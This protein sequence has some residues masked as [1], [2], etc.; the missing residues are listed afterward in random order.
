M[1]IDIVFDGIQYY[2]LVMD[3]IPTSYPMVI[4]F[5]L[6]NSTDIIK[7]ESITIM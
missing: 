4:L 7:T 5:G 3:K 2:E 1:I 6:D